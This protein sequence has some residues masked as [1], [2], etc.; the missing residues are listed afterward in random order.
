MGVI[1]LVAYQIHS[2]QNKSVDLGL[3][4]LSLTFGLDWPTHIH[5]QVH[6][7]NNVLIVMER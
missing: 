3:I 4:Q 2:W 1:L 6:T 5:P 7:L